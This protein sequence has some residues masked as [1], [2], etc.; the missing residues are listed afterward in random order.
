MVFFVVFIY[1]DTFRMNSLILE[2][3][4]NLGN[5]REN[6][7]SQS[8]NEVH[9]QRRG[10]RIELTKTF[11]HDPFVDSFGCW[12]NLIFDV[13]NQVYLRVD[14]NLLYR[15]QCYFCSFICLTR[16]T[17]QGVEWHYKSNFD[18]QYISTIKS[19]CHYNRVYIMNKI[20]IALVI[21]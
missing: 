20:G 3:N 7:E 4:E 5:R 19:S 15:Y 13:A 10:E 8:S 6:V 11:H 9:N 1:H 16:A 2:D 18:Q 21:L 12:T 17:I 14:Y